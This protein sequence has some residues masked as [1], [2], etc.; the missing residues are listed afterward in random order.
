MRRKTT[1]SVEASSHSK[2][3]VRVGIRLRQNIRS[4]RIE[5]VGFAYI[6]VQVGTLAHAPN[7]HGSTPA[8]IHAADTRRDNEASLHA[9]GERRVEPH[10]RSCPN[11]PILSTFL[12]GLRSTERY[13]A[14][15]TEDAVKAGTTTIVAAWISSAP[16]IHLRGSRVSSE[17]VVGPGSGRKWKSSAGKPICPSCRCEPKS[18]KVMVPRRRNKFAWAGFVPEHNTTRAWTTPEPE[19]EPDG[20]RARGKPQRQ[21]RPRVQIVSGGLPGLGKRQ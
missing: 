21:R 6:C 1:A 20:E 10:L 15:L 12:S 4:C 11:R 3:G 17:Q 9:C 18:L 5:Y 7:Q 19:P 16:V 13:P 14:S 8:V 2:L